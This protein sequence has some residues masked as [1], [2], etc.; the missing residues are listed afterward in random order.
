MMV[1]LIVPV[2]VA[3]ADIGDC[4]RGKARP[5][6]NRECDGLEGGWLEMR[7]THESFVK[8]A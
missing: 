8:R 4:W 5:T 1:V 7:L 2:L 3:G 6:N